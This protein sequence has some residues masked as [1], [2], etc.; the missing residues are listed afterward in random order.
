MA[1]TKHH[2]PEPIIHLLR[3]AEV[4]NRGVVIVFGGF[5]EAGFA[6]TRA[7]NNVTTVAKR[8]D[9]ACAQQIFIFNDQ[10]AHGDRRTGEGLFAAGAGHLLWTSQP[11]PIRSRSAFGIKVS[12]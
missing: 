3:Q 5:E 12:D 11:M 8:L 9:E 10:Q 6:V 7:V 1:K 4:D 2:T